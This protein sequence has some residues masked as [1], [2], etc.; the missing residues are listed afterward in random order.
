M[1]VLTIVGM[2]MTCIGAAALGLT[3]YELQ[4]NG[5]KTT[6]SNFTSRVI[7]NVLAERTPVGRPIHWAFAAGVVGISLLAYGAVKK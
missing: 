1:R 4:V 7:T 2:G 3:A 5:T 6:P